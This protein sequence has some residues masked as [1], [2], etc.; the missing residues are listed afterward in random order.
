[1]EKLT[2]TQRAVLSAKY[3]CWSAVSGK[4]WAVLEQGYTFAVRADT[5][6]KLQN[7]GLIRFDHKKGAVSFYLPTVVPA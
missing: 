1:M 2:K 6:E 3:V 5:L 4:T 7:A